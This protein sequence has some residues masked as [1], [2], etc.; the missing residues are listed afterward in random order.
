MRME[1]SQFRPFKFQLYC[2]YQVA[3]HHEYPSSVRLNAPH[4]PSVP[5]AGAAAPPPC[6][7]RAPPAPRALA[8]RPHAAR[9]SQLSERQY[10]A[11]LVDT[12]LPL[13]RPG[14]RPG[15]AAPP[16]GLGSFHQMYWL[17]GRLIAVGV[18]DV[19]PACLSSKYLF[20]EPELGALG[21]GK[22][23]ALREIE[24]VT[25]AG[26][27]RLSRRPCSTRRRVLAPI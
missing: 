27:A 13:L 20:R 9:R 25:L 4:P 10:R 8:A 18:V 26:L 21:L 22:W 7:R 15:R 19:L 12:P 16:C 24:W 3:V 2:R 23:T 11:F 5:R 17:D 6:A 1:P 14:Q